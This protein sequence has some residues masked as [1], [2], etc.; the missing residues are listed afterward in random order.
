M[1]VI[2][3][4]LEANGKFAANYDLRQGSRPEPRL[5]VVTRMDPRV[6]DI[7]GMLG[8]CRSDMDVIRTEGAAVTEDTFAEL[9]IS[10]R[11]LGVTEILVINHTVCGFTNIVDEELSEDFSET[12]GS[13]PV[14]W[15][16]S[17][18]RMDPEQDTKE[19]ILKIRSYPWIPMD[20][21]VRGAIF[22]V[23]TGRLREVT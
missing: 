4:A 9:L 6:F 22:D 2:D 12:I 8:L 21:S 19:Q 16:R 5:A 18:A 11:I 14:A 15:M 20:V 7:E 3:Q 13:T 10:T 23:K 1:G 17:F